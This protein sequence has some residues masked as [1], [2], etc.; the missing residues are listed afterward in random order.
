[1]DA[2]KNVLGSKL[3]SC[4]GGV[5]WFQAGFDEIVALR[6]LGHLDMDDS[7]SESCP[8]PAQFLDLAVGVP[9]FVFV[10]YVV[11]SSRDDARITIDEVLV[12]SYAY[13][14]IQALSE[15]EPD[16]SESI[17]VEGKDFPCLVRYWWD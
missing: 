7:Q 12:P 16:E 15:S 9:D 3:G 14:A 10:G 1:M 8:T 4:I 17:L 13:F 11:E 6:D 2:I 5:A